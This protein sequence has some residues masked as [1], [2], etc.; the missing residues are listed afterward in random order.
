MSERVPDVI[1]A[2]VIGGTTPLPSECIRMAREIQQ[3]REI[4]ARQPLSGISAQAAVVRL[5]EKLARYE[6]VVEAARQWRKHADPN[7]N[8]GNMTITRLCE[9]VDALDAKEQKR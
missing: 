6:R 5:E 3:R 9:A 2:N 1:V 7:R 8:G 4:E